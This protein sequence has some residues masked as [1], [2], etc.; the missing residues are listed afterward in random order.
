MVVRVDVAVVVGEIVVDW[1]LLWWKDVPV[2]VMVVKRRVFHRSVVVNDVV[3]WF[4]FFKGEIWFFSLFACFG[5]QEEW[6]GSK[7]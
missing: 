5:R 7:F 3:W 1:L 4:D 2:V 6:K